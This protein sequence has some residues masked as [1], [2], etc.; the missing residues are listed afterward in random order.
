MQKDMELLL[1]IRMHKNMDCFRS[2]CRRARK[3]LWTRQETA[4]GRGIRTLKGKSV[5]E[6][7]L[8]AVGPAAKGGH[9]IFG[10]GLKAD[11]MDNRI[12]RVLKNHF[13]LKWNKAFHPRDDLQNPRVAKN[14]GVNYR[15]LEVCFITNKNEVAYLKQNID[16][17]AKELASPITGKSVSDTSAT[18]SSSGQVTS[19]TYRI[20]TGTFATDASAN[21]AAIKIASLGFKVFNKEKPAWPGTVQTKETAEAAQGIIGEKLGFNPQIRDETK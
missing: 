6:F 15:L 2:F 11:A 20:F 21:A 17:I 4:S 16:Q 14:L 5:T 13:G 7:H 19:G 18:V 3:R 12:A 1:K 9:I 8:D 10:A